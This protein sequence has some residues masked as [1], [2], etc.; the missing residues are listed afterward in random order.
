MAVK[1]MVKSSTSVSA[2]N[3]VI[4]VVARLHVVSKAVADDL[5]LCAA[6]GLEHLHG[7]DGEHEVQSDDDEHQDD[8]EHLH[9]DD[10]ALLHHAHAQ[11]QD[12]PREETNAVFPHLDETE[13]DERIVFVFECV[14]ECVVCLNV[15]I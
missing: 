3:M 15:L 4:G 1:L 11:G 8:H 5:L 7:E 13:D 14:F 6:S 9:G 10:A 12:L 2:N